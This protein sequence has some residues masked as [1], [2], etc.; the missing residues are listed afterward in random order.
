MPS[1]FTTLFVDVGGVLLTH[2][3]SPVERLRAVEHFA[4][5][6]E[7]LDQRHHLAYPLYEEGKLSLK[8][9]LELTVFYRKRSF[10]WQDFQDFMFSQFNAWPQMIELVCKLKARHRLKVV[11][12]ANE[13]W[14]MAVHR[15][16]K[17]SLK[18]FVDFFIFSCFVRCRKPDPAI[19]QMAL[20]I[21][22]VPPQA[23]FCIE[24]QRIFEETAKSLGMHAFQHMSYIFT[25]DWLAEE[26][27][28]PE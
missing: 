18:T 26:G 14:E 3:W 25:R 21:A 6:R 22:Q 28:S 19:Y 15:I 27:L 5:D 16:E 13:G 10:T 11:A 12:V 24:D 17:F 20:D 7:P 4:L 2:A 9:Y 8:E 1:R 23:V